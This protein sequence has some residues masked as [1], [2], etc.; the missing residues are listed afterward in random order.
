MVVIVSKVRVGRWVEEA[1]WVWTLSV[2]QCCNYTSTMKALQPPHSPVV[3][4]ATQ[5]AGVFFTGVKKQRSG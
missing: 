1:Q 2:F 4:H 5:A 3:S